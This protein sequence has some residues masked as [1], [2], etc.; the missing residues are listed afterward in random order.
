MCSKLA[1]S[2]EV[3]GTAERMWR[4]QKKLMARLGAEDRSDPQPPRPR[5]MHENTYQRLLERIWAIE[6]WGDEQLY[7]FMRRSGLA[8]VS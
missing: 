4:K 3:E 8:G 6:A 7:R 2:S 5:G 1:F